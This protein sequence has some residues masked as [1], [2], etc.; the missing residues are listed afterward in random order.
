MVYLYPSAATASLHFNSRKEKFGA[1]HSTG[2]SVFGYPDGSKRAYWNESEGQLACSGRLLVNADC[3]IWRLIGQW[4]GT[5]AGLGLWQ[6]TRLHGAA[7]YWGARKGW[8][9][10]IF[11]AHYILCGNSYIAVRCNLKTTRWQ[12]SQI[13]FC[14]GPRNVLNRPRFRLINLMSFYL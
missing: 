12:A 2:E 8:L 14:T 13:Y 4:V 7:P 1:L 9:Y 5:G 11:R 6:C 3:E 10:F